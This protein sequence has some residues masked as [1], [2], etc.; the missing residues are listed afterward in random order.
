MSFIITV[1]PYSLIND[2]SVDGEREGMGSL[3][4][5]GRGSWGPFSAG[6][7]AVPAKAISADKVPHFSPLVCSKL[8]LMPV[9]TACMLVTTPHWAR[10][11]SLDA[12]WINSRPAVPLF[13]P[14]SV[15]IVLHQ[16]LKL[17]RTAPERTHTRLWC[18]IN[19]PPYPPVV[20]LCGSIHCGAACGS[21]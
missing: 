5:G 14:L 19:H 21:P 10:F 11:V 15:S 13:P 7:P 16:Y 20:A 3:F 17:T 18:T 6:T 12:T 8:L 1:W 9:H 4:D 2:G